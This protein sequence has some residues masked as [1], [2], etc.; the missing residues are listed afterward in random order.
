MPAGML[1]ADSLRS[2]LIQPLFMACNCRISLT[3]SSRTARVLTV[4]NS[5]INLAVREEA[6]WAPTALLWR[7]SAFFLRHSALSTC[8]RAVLR[9]ACVHVTTEAL[10]DSLAEL[11]RI[12]CLL[13]R[14]SA[15]C[16]SSTDRAR[17]SR[18]NQCRPSN[19]A[20][21]SRQL[22]LSLCFLSRLPPT[23][24]EL[25]STTKPG[26]TTRSCLQGSQR[27]T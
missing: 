9:L 4:S 19:G 24:H 1:P 25:Y 12:L 2:S 13:R 15:W 27:T 20:K 5:G 23:M 8:D 22:V 16:P 14:A 17:A 6:G 3:S 11:R 10:R 21:R 7:T 26:N 18:H